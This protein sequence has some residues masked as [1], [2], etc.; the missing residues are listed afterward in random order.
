[1]ERFTPRGPTRKVFFHR[2]GEDRCD[3]NRVFFLRQ[4]AGQYAVGTV[5]RGF[6]STADR[7]RTAK[8]VRTSHGE[9]RLP[10]FRL[11]R[12]MG[13]DPAR[14]QALVLARV[15][16]GPSRQGEGVRHCAVAEKT[17]GCRIAHGRSRRAPGDPRNVLSNR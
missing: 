11:R 13:H 7:S 16:S 3:P 2:N 12:T 10:G 15:D 1:M 6:W 4:L 9:G 17:G 5:H 14:S 8:L